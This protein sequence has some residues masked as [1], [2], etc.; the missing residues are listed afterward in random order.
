MDYRQIVIYVLLHTYF[1]F[2]RCSLPCPF[3]AKHRQK[4]KGVSLN[5]SMMISTSAAFLFHKR[6]EYCY[7]R[8]LDSG[9][10]CLKP[11]EKWQFQD[12]KRHIFIFLCIIEVFFGEKRHSYEKSHTFGAESCNSSVET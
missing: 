11:Q 9:Q 7:L 5:G 4:H 10:E 8:T 3:S 6:F 1:L 2:T 12:V